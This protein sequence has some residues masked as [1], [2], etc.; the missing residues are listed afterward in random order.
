MTPIA[1]ANASRPRL[2]LSRGRLG[3]GAARGEYHPP[4]EIIGARSAP[5]KPGASPERGA[6]LSH[7]VH[8]TK[9]DHNHE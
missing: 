2:R 4:H 5:Q 9:G 8:E 1:P 6:A 7:P 3:P